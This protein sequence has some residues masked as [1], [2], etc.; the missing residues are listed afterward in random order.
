MN[1]QLVVFDL[2]G[3]TVKDDDGV[4]ICFRGA[5]SAVGVEAERDVVNAMMGLP[6]PLAIRKLLE[7]ANREDLFDQIDEIHNDFSERMIQFYRT[8]ASVVEIEGTSDVFRQL[9]KAGIKIAVNTGFHRKITE[10]LL[11]RLGWEHEGLIDTHIS[12]DE[13][14]QGRPAPNMIREIMNRLHI[15]DSQTIAK[16]GDTPADLEEGNNAGCGLVIGVTEGTHSR[17]QLSSYP[18]THLIDTVRDLPLVLRT[19]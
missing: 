10:V 1:I 11:E 7:A 14:E 16:I 9:K 5:L 8:D 17:E 4:N 13:V 2:A 12:S 18:H 3:T 19:T 15:D 6:K